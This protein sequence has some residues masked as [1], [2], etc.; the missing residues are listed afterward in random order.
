MR[1]LIIVAVA[2]IVW[3]GIVIG[4]DLAGF[5]HQRPWVSGFLALFLW[6][7]VSAY[8]KSRRPKE[9]VGPTASYDWSNKR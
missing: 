9:K 3:F 4:M 1:I 7:V 8:L 5:E 6:Y 2:V